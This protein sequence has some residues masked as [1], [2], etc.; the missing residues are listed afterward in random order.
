M[1]ISKLWKNAKLK[2]AGIKIMYSLKKKKKLFTAVAFTWQQ[3][4]T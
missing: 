3:Q 2:E 1:Y 4:V